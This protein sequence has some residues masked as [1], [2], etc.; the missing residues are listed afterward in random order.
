MPKV[1]T[2]IPTITDVDELVS[3]S[4][5][6]VRKWVARANEI[7]A[8]TA[9]TRLAGLLRDPNGLAFAVGFIDG[10]IRPESLR[11]SARN[12]R[13]LT[14]I[15]PEFLPNFLR[16]LI[17][18]GGTFATIVPWAVVPIARLVLRSMV[19]HLIIDA[20]PER[21]GAALKRIR[22]RGVSLNINLLGEAVL[23]PAEANTRL[24][25]TKNLL[26][27]DDVDYVSVKVSAVVAPHSKW[28]F[29]E[30]VNDIVEA[31]LPL[32]R[33]AASAKT[34]KFI[35]LDMEEY[36]DLDLTIAV[37][38][39]LLDREELRSL[40]AGIVLQAYLP[41]ALGA[42]IKLQEWA[43]K[44]K[45]AGGAGIKVRVVKGANLPMETVDAE[46][47]GWELATVRSK[48]EADT[49]YKRVINYAL[50]KDNIENIRI[51]VA[52]HNLFDIAF[53]WELAGKRG[54][55][56]GIE[57]EMLLGMAE[58]Q[59]KAVQET[60]GSLLL[61]TP[62][63]KPTEFSVAIAYLIRRL[64]EGAS[65]DNFM[66]A[67][68]E[69]DRATFFERERK[70]FI[71]SVKL[72]DRKVPGPNRSAA[73]KPVKGTDFFNVSDSDPAIEQVREWGMGIIKQAKKR[74]IGAA[75]VKSATID[76]EE[77]LDSVLA[78]AVRG[79]TA[80]GKTPATNRAAIL[81]KV[82]DVLEENR[83][84]L[85]EV[86][87]SETG[88][89]IDQADPEISEA[90]DFARY[91]AA[92]AEQ[93]EKISG[94]TFEPRRVTVVT[95]PWNFPIAI[96]A[97]S[98]LSALAA[99]SAVVFKPAKQAAR[100][101]ALLASLMWKA[102]V[103]KSALFSVQ[104]S[105]SGLGKQLISDS[106]VDQV[107]LTGGFETAALFREFKPGL[108]LLAETSGKNAIVVTESADFDLAAKDVAYS[109]FGHA[110]QK[111]S[112]ASLVILVGAV[113]K[114]AHFRRQLLDAVDAQVVGWPTDP[115]TTVGP[116]IEAANG[117]LQQALTTL[118]KGE[119]WLRQPAQL[120]KTARL[121]SPGIKE[122]VAR[123]AVSHLT[124]FF[125]P[126]LSIMTARTLEE[127]IDIQNQVDYG[128]TAGIH[129]LDRNEVGRWLDRVQA[130]NLYVNRG[131]TGAIVQRQ[132]FGGWKKSAIGTGA[133][134]GGPNYLIGLGDW[135]RSK[136]DGAT[137]TKRPLVSEIL[138]IAANSLSV[139]DQ[140]ALARSANSD[141]VALNEEFTR[142][143]DVSALDSEVN[144]F[145]YRPSGCKLA[146]GGNTASFD[147]W[148]ALIA[149]AAVE[150][151]GALYAH[152]LP[153]GLDKLLAKHGRKW[154]HLDL[155]Q[156]KVDVSAGFGGRIRLV[157]VPNNP[158]TVKGVDNVAVAVYDSEV[159]ESGRIEL[160]PYFVEQAV[161]ITAHRFGNPVKWVRE[162]SL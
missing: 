48:L 1:A 95:P 57:F 121:W 15:V 8:G 2:T 117:K 158:E 110:G 131:I 5:K 149:W 90:I 68:F 33:Q 16:S 36:H 125:G 120:D 30:S 22:E 104:L 123:G 150:R 12:F 127:A 100:C 98:A 152:S 56:G 137:A 109:A 106:R 59:A 122:G 111:C 128:L 114:S 142:I 130:G 89:T 133:K 154:Q 66:S 71:E 159:T 132:P 134:A 10:V 113:G 52:G 135:K 58:S 53:A 155:L 99:G 41:D 44:R 37:F 14:G 108:K 82:A 83:A 96:P 9:S 80:W 11:V 31:L 94:A 138:T 144:A 35:N 47:H 18:I 161:S 81:R 157:G 67:V 107:I 78:S 7:P 40:E 91:Y 65:S 4:I 21:L 76:T 148:R 75:Q 129:S 61:Y 126:V 17:K 13:A 145:R 26:N 50:A 73:R 119:T 42:M 55:R 23:G 43:R 92:Q 20:S 34:R 86:A 151:P 45:A 29:A 147:W 51:G 136:W 105:E 116:I 93:L 25:G 19:R 54:V 79:G 101:G 87:M 153:Y 146:L 102:G 97:G 115:K 143:K 62:V 64:E 63:V 103:P 77:K 124:E 85:I 3:N 70:R 38:Q 27:R 74:E 28:A 118:D 24:S 46:M 160:L 88:K 6:Q 49:N 84:E 39:N 72:L 141:A 60:T 32:Y 112:A 139:D 162:L 69:L 156:G 140:R